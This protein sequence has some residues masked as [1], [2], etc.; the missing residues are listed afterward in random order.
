MKNYQA[1]TPL[2][3]FKTSSKKTYSQQL[4]SNK[5]NIAALVST[6][7]KMT[8][9]FPL[10][11]FPPQVYG[12]CPIPSVSLLLDHLK[13]SSSDVFLDLGSGES[14]ISQ[15]AKRFARLKKESNCFKHVELWQSPNKTGI[16][17]V[18]LQVAAEARCKSVG[19]EIREDLH[20]LALVR[21]FLSFLSSLSYFSY[22]SSS[23]SFSCSCSCS[24]SSSCSSSSFFSS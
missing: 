8:F 20:A 11:F 16:G 14:S 7:Q 22:F 15:L 6:V 2:V 10:S 17:N 12:E 9:P 3:L 13:L 4:R 1:G 23:S 18:V 24:C 5:A 19:I 21:P